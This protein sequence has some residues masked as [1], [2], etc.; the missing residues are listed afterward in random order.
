MSP[1]KNAHPWRERQAPPGSTSRNGRRIAPAALAVFLWSHGAMAEDARQSPDP[2]PEITQ[3]PI[4]FDAERTRLTI[5]Y[6]RLHN[7]TPA[8][9]QPDYQAH[10]DPRVVVLH[11]TAGTTADA[12]YHTFAPTRL[13]GR[14]D[15][16][17]SGA[18]NV[19]AH[20]LVDQDGSIAQ[21][22][23]DHKVGRHTIGLNHVAIG[24]EN[25]GRPPGMPL[26]EA[27]VAANAALVR[28]L[29]SRHRITHLI[30]HHEYRMMEET[31][32]FVET[33]PDYR[34]TKVDPG[35]AFMRSVRDKVADLGLEG[36]PPPP[37]PNTPPKLRAASTGASIVETHS[38]Q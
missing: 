37:G 10:M 28:C 22:L 29:V 30:G 38:S 6:L 1:H 9:L 4:P 8:I 16:R 36:P 19:S 11:W 13:R 34:T 23:S 3:R 33:D 24:I 12:A 17:D 7:G 25:V 15:L 2:C 21:L 20:Y 35:D 27:Q 26:T 14:P 18:V 31:S 5:A 32:L